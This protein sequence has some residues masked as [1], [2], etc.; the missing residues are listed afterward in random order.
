ML[1]QDKFEERFTNDDFITV[2][3]GLLVAGQ[4]PG[5]PIDECP[6]G[7]SHVFNKI[8]IIK[9]LNSCVSP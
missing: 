4:Q 7:A 8:L 1:T 5:T 3:Q 9:K 2:V 6:V